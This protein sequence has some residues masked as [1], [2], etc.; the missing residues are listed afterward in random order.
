MPDG[1]VAQHMAPILFSTSPLAPTQ[2]LDAWNAVFG[3]LNTIRLP[4]GDAK[5]D[6][7]GAHWEV[8]GAIVSR[9]RTSAAR[10][11]RE[12]Q[13]LRLDGLDHWVIRLLLRGENR[14]AH[15]G[16]SARLGAGEVVLFS[17][18]DS[19]VCEW[20]D[21]EWV[22]LTLP[23]AFDPELSRAFETLRPGPLRGAPAELLANALAALPARLIAARAE[24]APA[25]AQSIRGL[26]HASLLPS[27]PPA[28]LAKERARAAIRRR[29]ASARLTPASLA[30]ELGMSRSALYR[31]FE[32]EGGVAREILALR[33]AAAQA[34][35]R[36]PARRGES[37]ALVG[38]AH[39][40][41]DP[42]VFSRSFRRAFG[43]PPGALRSAARAGLEA[44][45]EVDLAALLYA[46]SPPNG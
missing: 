11:L 43:L 44:G 23:R 41:P 4:A 42:A 1:P 19:W 26:L 3:R 7:Q 20:S 6:V 33:L 22:S 8:G 24:Q 28:L 15:D 34:A 45:P 39:G 36:D 38:A 14:L 9:N 29:L 17:M 32:A 13:H 35:L 10:F 46:A 21:A 27:A 12:P 5:V 37:V 18:R 40:F 30:A 2:R 25:L 16:F 31:V